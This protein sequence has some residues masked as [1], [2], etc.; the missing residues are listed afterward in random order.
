MW[1]T[2]QPIRTYVE[3]DC[4]QQHVR[5]SIKLL[6]FVGTHVHQHGL[7]TASSNY[8]SLAA[9]SIARAV[10]AC[11]VANYAILLHL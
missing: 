7:L 9:Y 2:R 5:V 10:T 11:M 6:Y 4:V 8:T 3:S 1:R